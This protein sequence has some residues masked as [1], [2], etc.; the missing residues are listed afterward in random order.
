MALQFN[1]HV[2][3][4][5]TDGVLV[6]QNIQTTTS[7]NGDEC[8]R[9]LSTRLFLYGRPRPAETKTM[10]WISGWCQGPLGGN[11]HWSSEEL[12]Q[13][14][15]QWLQSISSHQNPLDYQIVQSIQLL[16]RGSLKEGEFF[17]NDHLRYLV[18]RDMARYTEIY[19]KNN[20]PLGHNGETLCSAMASLSS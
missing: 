11:R 13:A 16:L 14:M 9:Q 1:E 7:C 5:W 8:G 19:M 15:Q 4:E 10:R 12:D 17:G 20:A 2:V 18:M 3:E 6:I